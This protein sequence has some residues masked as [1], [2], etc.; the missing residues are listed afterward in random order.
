MIAL[1]VTTHKI[2]VFANIPQSYKDLLRY[3]MFN[4]FAHGAHRAHEHQRKIL[5]ERDNLHLKNI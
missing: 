5:P 2:L 3:F 1:I 4:S